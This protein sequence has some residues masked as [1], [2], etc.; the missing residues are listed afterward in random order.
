MELKAGDIVVEKYRLDTPI[1]QGGMGSVWRA[2]HLTIGRAVAIK[3]LD[4]GGTSAERR[5]DRFLREAKIAAAIRHRNIVDIVDYGVIGSTQ[6]F[7]V[8]ELL[9]GRSLASRLDDPEPL[10]DIELLRIVAQ[11][12]AGLAAVHAT[13]IVHRDMKPDNVLL[14]DDDGA[15]EPKIV[16]FG[17]SRAIDAETAPSG[18]ITNTGA[19]LGTPEYMSP[20]QARGMR[21]IDG[22]SDLFSVGVILYEGLAGRPPFQAENPGDILIM[23]ATQDPRPL[24]LARA[25]LPEA[26]LDVVDRALARDRDARYATAKEMRDAVLAAIAACEARGAARPR[27]PVAVERDRGSRTLRA[28]LP[29]ELRRQMSPETTR[30]GDDLVLKTRVPAA[31][32]LVAMGLLVSVVAFAVWALGDDHA[33]AGAA[34]SADP[35]DHALHDLPAS[36]PTAPPTPATAETAEPSLPPPL[37]AALEPPIAPTAV[38]APTADD[39]A[40]PRSRRASRRP[41]PRESSD[42]V[43]PSGGV[44]RDLDY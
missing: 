27:Q 15:Y 4:G 3:F 25:D 6:P 41:S 14:V 22:R 32:P 31:V 37:P 1:G 33:N 7:I 23:I 18:R 38:A 40:G 30:T 10:P 21:T 16:D 24:D 39:P 12:L 29:L 19:I 26:V 13:G 5:A 44:F 8:M 35:A 42:P 11:L 2:T 36:A 43:E 17:I 28:E 20:E 34:P 9:E